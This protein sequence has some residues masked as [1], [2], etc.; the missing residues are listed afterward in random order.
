MFLFPSLLWGNT[1]Q[2]AAWVPDP[3]P[4]PLHKVPSEML[5]VNEPMPLD[6]AGRCGRCE[7]RRHIKSI[8]RISSSISWS[9][10]QT[11]VRRPLAISSESPP[12]VQSAS[13]SIEFSE[14]NSG[15]EIVVETDGDEQQEQQNET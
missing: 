12:S 2:Y 15:Y 7:R 3:L 13:E 6:T 11:R 14:D 4:S 1:H 10:T 5:D 9:G 8:A